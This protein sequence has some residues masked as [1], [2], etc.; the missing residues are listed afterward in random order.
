MALTFKYTLPSFTDN[1]VVA[2]VAEYLGAQEVTDPHEVD[3]PRVFHLEAESVE[4]IET[5][6]L[7]GGLGS[8]LR[9]RIISS[10]TLA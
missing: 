1:G 2:F 4:E 5:V 7:Y 6:L 9:A 3:S 10:A 8:E